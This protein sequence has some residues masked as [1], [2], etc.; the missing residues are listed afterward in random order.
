MRKRII[1][2]DKS[3]FEEVLPNSRTYREVTLRLDVYYCSAA[4]TRI[5]LAAKKYNID[6]SHL[7]SKNGPSI[8][9]AFASLI[10][11]G[12]K[13]CLKDKRLRAGDIKDYAVFILYDA[14]RNDKN[15]GLENDLT[16]DFVQSTLFSAG[17]C[18][19]CEDSKS[20]LTLDR[21]NNNKGHTMDNVV[22]SCNNCN[23]IRGN[24]PYD[25]WLCI[26]PGVK[27]AK[28]SGLLDNWSAY[29]R[30]FG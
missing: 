24:I 28:Q 6:I 2:I 11:K 15:R 3:L 10:T 4:I 1:D 20:K 22:V 13:R 27:Q 14:R 19:Y 18:S 29:N 26:A 5:R 16:L 25:A 9:K 7:E 23:T 12:Q 21:I 8:D 30:R 17:K